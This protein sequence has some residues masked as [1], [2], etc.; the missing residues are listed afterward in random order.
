MIQNMKNQA[1]PPL[2]NNSARA[3]VQAKLV[4]EWQA[5]GRYAQRGFSENAVVALNQAGYVYPEALLFADPS[6]LRAVKGIGPAAL[7][8]IM[9]YRNRFL[10]A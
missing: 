7:K 8:Q 2:A 3:E 10:S 4:V 6:E 5:Q 9:A 1:N